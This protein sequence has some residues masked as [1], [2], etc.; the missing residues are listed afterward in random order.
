MMND[1]RTMLEN[2]I[3]ELRRRSQSGFLNEVQNSVTPI[4]ATM[5][6]QITEDDYS[7]LLAAVF[8]D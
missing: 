5:E 7:A 6:A 4:T 2:N 3:A 1:N 8:D